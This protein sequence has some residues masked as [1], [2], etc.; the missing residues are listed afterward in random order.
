M[1]SWLIL[2]VLNFQ[3]FSILGMKN[4]LLYVF[5]FFQLSAFVFFEKGKEKRKINDCRPEET[6]ELTTHQNIFCIAW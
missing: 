3:D 5:E 6:Q 4:Y 2:I 1:I